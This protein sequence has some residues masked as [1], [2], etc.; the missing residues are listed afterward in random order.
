VAYP[1]TY[2]ADFTP[3]R[4][5]L[6]TFF[7]YFLAIP[8]FIVAIVYAIGVM[9]TVPIA[10]F[11]IVFTGR[12]P[13]GLYRF[14]AGFLQFVARINGYVSLVTDAY[15]P[16]GLGEADYPIRLGMPD[17]LPEYSRMKALFRI[18]LAIP[19]YIIAYVLQLVGM[20]ATVIS[21]FWIVITGQQNDG[22]HSA[23]VLAQA[24]N[25]KAYSYYFLI[26]ESWPPFSEEG[27]TVPAAPLETGSDA[28]SFRA[29]ESAATGST[30]PPAG[31]SPFAQRDDGPPAG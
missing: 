14:N 19:V 28:G 31:A 17:P 13:E 30:A 10:W 2:A 29:P 11:V 21:W 25:M 27:G 18:I 4:S 9:F 6:T 8:L 3:D 23:I 24:Y 16:F 7:R 26:T 20:V 5:R 15:P 22:L 1:V 12:Y